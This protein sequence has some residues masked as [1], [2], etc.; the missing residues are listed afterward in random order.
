LETFA[1]L[2]H[3][4]Q[5]TASYEDLCTHG[6]LRNFRSDRSPAFTHTFSEV[7]KE[8]KLELTCVL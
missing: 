8:T 4:K 3:D 6:I 2:A 7:M 1:A 5:G